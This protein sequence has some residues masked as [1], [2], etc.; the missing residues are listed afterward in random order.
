M[1][2]PVFPTRTRERVKSGSG[3]GDDFLLKTETATFLPSP[4]FNPVQF[5]S[6]QSDTVCRVAVACFK[7]NGC[8]EMG[9]DVYFSFHFVTRGARWWP[10][11]SAAKPHRTVESFSRFSFLGGG[12]KKTG[13]DD[14]LLR[15]G[16][17][18]EG[19][20]LEAMCQQN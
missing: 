9:S 13:D 18:E 14:D 3:G 16:M 7:R 8:P 10:G 4:G 12:G 17:V 1:L 11:L 5:C 19:R 6:S 15:F 20:W 2:R